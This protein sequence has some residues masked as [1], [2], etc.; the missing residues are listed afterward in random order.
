M[1]QERIVTSKHL[2]YPFV[3]WY[4]YYCGGGE[5]G[6]HPEIDILGISFPHKYILF[7]FELS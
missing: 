7:P 1:P 3:I 2:S 4:C 5:G 6:D